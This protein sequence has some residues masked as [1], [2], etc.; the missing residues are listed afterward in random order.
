MYRC[1]TGRD[2]KDMASKNN[3]HQKQEAGFTIIELMIASLVFSVIL[4]VITVGITSFTRSYYKGVRSSAVQNRARTV[5]DTVAQS[6]EFS[7][8][9]ITPTGTNN[10][11]CTG[12]KVFSFSPGVRY[13]GTVSAAN[14]GLYQQDLPAGGSCP[15]SA[16]APTNG[17]ELLEPNMRVSNMVVRPVTGA[18]T[19]NMYQIVLR[20][21]YGEDDLLNNPTGTN[22]SCDLRT[23]SQFCAVSE[24]STI[25]Q[26]RVE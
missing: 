11:F 16:P 19:T 23:G 4:V 13:T 21:A 9:T 7:G 15:A 17:R 8:T 20:I 14:R 26:K 6:I 22:A 12:G 25:V 10:H 24:L 1:V 3:H 2:F 5:V 18:G